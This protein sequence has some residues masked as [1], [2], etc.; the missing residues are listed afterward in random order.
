MVESKIAITAPSPTSARSLSDHQEILE[1][2][3]TVESS[4]V[5]VD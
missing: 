1:A 2:Q 5:V 3:Q 4:S